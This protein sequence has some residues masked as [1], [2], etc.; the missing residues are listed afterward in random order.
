MK[1]EYIA[2]EV[3]VRSIDIENAFCLNTSD[4]EGSGEQFGKEY[5]DEDGDFWE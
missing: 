5:D 4:T 3:A 2:P 1:K